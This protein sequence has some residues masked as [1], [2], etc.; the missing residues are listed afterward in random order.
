M[1]ASM[2]LFPLLALGV[3]ARADDAATARDLEQKRL[4][5]SAFFFYGEALRH[6]K[7]GP[8]AAQAAAGVQRISE[9]LHDEVFGPNLLAR[10][11]PAT[12][13]SLPPDVS[14]RVHAALALLQYRAGKLEDAKREASAVPNDSTAFP[15]AQYVAGLLAQRSQP[16]GAVAIFEGVLSDR[17]SSNELRELS[18]LALARTLYGLRRYPEAS[19]EYGK[20]PRFSRHWDE[21]LF[22]GAYADLMRGD[23]GSAL[24][25]L[26][27]LHSPHLSDE[28]APESE[29]LAAIVYHQHCLWPQVRTALKRFD[30]I[31]LPMRDQVR[32]VLARDPAP[33]A[34]LASLDGKGDV[35]LPDPVRHHLRK[36]ERV[37]SMLAYAAK[38]DDEERRIRGDGELSRSELGKELLD[39][40]ARHRELT[41]G[42]TAKF[43]RNRL[44]D[45]AHLIDVL[46]GDKD[47]VAFE[48]TKGEKGFLEKDV[49]AKKILSA[50]VLYRPEQPATGHEYWAFDGEYWPDEI[51][52]YQATIKDACPARKEPEQP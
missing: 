15:Q 20:L 16:E 39:I 37:E 3:A 18:H 42:V 12:I 13:A 34:L 48:A 52:Y 45:L 7:P 51:G 30:L 46:E 6:A 11:D 35:R 22:E 17:R 14:P 44:E 49:D 50:E 5:V 8:D 24:G 25:K 26:Q 4:P 38:V 10:L 41:D 9:A 33:A 31:Y 2:A 32:A 19:A 43:V 40:V 36:N 47:V 23:P 27:S 21:A 28:F 29:N 1:R